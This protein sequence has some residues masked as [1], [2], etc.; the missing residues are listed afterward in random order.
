M[1]PLDGGSSG[2]IA[3]RDPPGGGVARWWRAAAATFRLWL[4]RMRQRD[5]LARMTGYERQDIGI[6]DYDARLE[7]RKPFWRA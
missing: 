3:S 6:T 4:R 5:E 2:V 1:T 7:A